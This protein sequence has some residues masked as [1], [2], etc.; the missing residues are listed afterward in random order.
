MADQ[1]KSSDTDL[2]LRRNAGASRRLRI[3][4]A[5]G[6]WTLSSEA[7]DAPPASAASPGPFS[8]LRATPSTPPRRRGGGGN[9]ATSP[10]LS[11]VVLSQITSARLSRKEA[12]FGGAADDASATIGRG[13]MG[14][15]SVIDEREAY[16]SSATIGSNYRLHSRGLTM[17]L[18]Q[19]PQSQM[20]KVAALESKAAAGRGGGGARGVGL[21]HSA[22]AP[23]PVMPVSP[24]PRGRHKMNRG[25]KPRVRVLDATAW[26]PSGPGQSFEQAKME[27]IRSRTLPTPHPFRVPRP[28]KLLMTSNDDWVIPR[29]TRNAI[30]KYWDVLGRGDDG[31]G[32]FDAQAYKI[33][34][35]RQAGIAARSGIAA[36]LD[37]S[38]YEDDAPATTPGVPLNKAFQ[39]VMAEVASE[40]VAAN[41]RIGLDYALLNPSRSGTG[42]DPANLRALPEWWTSTEYRCPSWRVLRHTGVAGDVFPRCLRALGAYYTSHEWSSAAHLAQMWYEQ[43]TRGS[44]GGMKMLFVDLESKAMRDNY[45]IAPVMFLPICTDAMDDMRDALREHFLAIVF[46]YLVATTRGMGSQ[47]MDPN[48]KSAAASAAAAKAPV[49]GVVELR[50][51]AEMKKDAEKMAAAAPQTGTGKIGGHRMSEAERDRAATRL[52][53]RGVIFLWKQLRGL[54]ESTLEDFVRSFA[55]RSAYT[56]G[57]EEHVHAYASPRGLTLRML[58][59]S[60]SKDTRYAGRTTRAQ[61]LVAALQ[62]ARS[63]STAFE[64]NLYG[65]G[66]V[67]MNTPFL[68]LSLNIQVRSTTSSEGEDAEN[69]DATEAG[70]VEIFITPT[71]EELCATVTKSIDHLCRVTNLSMN[72]ASEAHPATRDAEESDDEVPNGGEGDAVAQGDGGAGRG[73]SAMKRAFGATFT[74]TMVE[75][76][77]RSVHEILRFEYARVESAHRQMLKR[78]KGIFH[79][80][81]D[82]EVDAVCTEEPTGKTALERCVKMIRRIDRTMRKYQRVRDDAD[83]SVASR[84]ASNLFVLNTVNFKKQTRARVDGLL[85]RLSAHA[86]EMNHDKMKSLCSEYSEITE[87][88]V[89]QPEDSDELKELQAFFNEIQPRI[90]ELRETVQ[91]EMFRLVRFITLGRPQHF[92]GT[93]DRTLFAALFA[94]PT[95][96]ESVQDRSINIQNA[97]KVKREE[98]LRNRKRFFAK[99]L[100]LVERD[101]SKLL[102][103]HSLERPDVIRTVKK[104]QSLETSIEEH[105]VECDDIVQQDE[106]L[107]VESSEDFKAQVEQQLKELKPFKD[108]WFTVSNK[109]ESFDKWYNEPLTELNPEEIEGDADDL[110]RQLIKVQKGFENNEQ[111]ALGELAKTVG[112]ECSDFLSKMLPLMTLLCTRGMKKRHWAAINDITGLSIRHTPEAN[113]KQMVSYGLHLHVEDIEETCINAS[114]EYSLESSLNKMEEEWEGI[115]FGTKPYK[116]TGTAILASLEEI[117]TILDDQIVRAQAMRGSRYITPFIDR[118]TKWEKMLSTLEDLIANWLKVQATWLYLEPIFSSADIQKQMPTEAKRFATVD[119]TWRDVMK[120]CEEDPRVTTIGEKQGMLDRLIAANHLLELIQKGLADYLNT[121]RVFFPRFFFLSNDELLEILSE[122]KDPTKVQPHLRKCFEGIQA[123]Q[124]DKDMA[125]THMISAEKEKV[126]FEYDSIGEKLIQPADTGGVRRDLARSDPERDAQNNGLYVRHFHGNV[127]G[128]S[129]KGRA[130]RVAAALAGANCARRDADLLDDGN[131]A[132]FDG[133]QE[134][135]QGRSTALRG[136]THGVPQRHCC[137]GARRSAQDRAQ[138]NLRAVRVGCALTRHDPGPCQRQHHIADGL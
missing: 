75:R 4:S 105:T 74:E 1:K 68:E 116:E 113:L 137:H 56:S 65:R 18:L 21:R 38:H 117:E 6:G 15:F 35:A 136:Q 31:S 95:E 121:K 11:P 135:R 120:E 82:A 10:P 133:S 81:N 127:W 87:K 78:F 8:S 124:F 58:D 9:P 48:N 103:V 3:S 33:S 115:G 23:L 86:V 97:E 40:Y 2:F 129:P 49:V 50:M 26:D 130:H 45:P 55:K 67:I 51:Q 134:R 126:K 29:A 102:D 63:A 114:K 100:T 128:A 16:G 77:K 47:I 125:I 83:L 112:L 37:S 28:G 25:P 90:T 80:N 109:N 22:S 79:A 110:R 85:S 64:D 57:D 36:G 34:D 54:F 118:I 17:S 131:D 53:E 98:I 88:L 61:V 93:G 69:N 122:T 101:I 7:G 42:I 19:A 59:V 13:F 44:S 41:Q 132:L 76:A 43:A 104:I 46:A 106:L 32:N 89:K 5:S 12:A 138:D 20:Q 14:P 66:A 62:H 72:D 92:L 73:Q 39:M 119:R 52:V 60:P 24:E 108:L 123:L 27:T 96:M 70:A 71:V 84:V 111:T 30:H 107:Q 99:E 94:W 91:G